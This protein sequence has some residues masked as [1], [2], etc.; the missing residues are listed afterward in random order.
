MTSLQLWIVVGVPTLVAVLVLL[1]GGNA[2]R[3][4]IALGVLVA[5]AVLF[6][7]AP[8][9]GGASVAFLAF[10]A[11]VLVAGGRLE[12]PSPEPHHKGRRRYTTAEG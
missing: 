12:G 3:A 9:T 4:R 10:L 5:L 7:V 6:T 1:V 11:I 8:G 2:V